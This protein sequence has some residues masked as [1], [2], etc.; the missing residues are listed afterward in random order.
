MKKFMT[1]IAY[2]LLAITLAVCTLTVMAINPVKTHAA[3]KAH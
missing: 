2:R 1:K 3:E